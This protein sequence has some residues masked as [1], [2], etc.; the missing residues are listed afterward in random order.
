MKIKKRFLAISLLIPIALPLFAI[1]CANYSERSSLNK[2]I[3]TSQVVTNK[4]IDNNEAKSEL[5]LNNLLSR[6][7][8]NEID[9]VNFLNQQNDSN[10]QNT[11]LDQLNSLKQDF[12]KAKQDNNQTQMDLTANKLADLYSQN[13][14]FFF[15]NL[16]K[17]SG[18]FKD[19]V[20]INKTKDNFHSAQYLNQVKNKTPYRDFRYL[21]NY[22]DSIKVGEESAEL[23]DSS[24]LYIAKDKSVFRV[25]IRNESLDKPTLS[26]RPYIWYFGDFGARNISLSIISRIWHSAVIHNYQE[27]YELFEKSL[28]KDQNYGIPAKFV[29]LPKTNA[30]QEESPASQTSNTQ[31]SKTQENEN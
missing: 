14:Y 11:L 31:E 28:I 7:F 22:I 27:G 2:L 10:Y 17:F 4:D 26:I 12:L 25:T 6:T 18:T 21:T 3:D 16:S 9:R 20:I 19:F 29:L 23:G 5:I 13:W 15:K 30:I 8:K 1:S 24:V